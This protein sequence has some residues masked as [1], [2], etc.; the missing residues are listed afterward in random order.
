VGYSDAKLKKP[1]AGVVMVVRGTGSRFI[2]D[3]VA[4]LSFLI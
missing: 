1:D 2:R 4:T 3:I